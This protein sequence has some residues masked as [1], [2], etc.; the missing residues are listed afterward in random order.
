MLLKMHPT[1]RLKFISCSLKTLSVA[2]VSALLFVNAHAAGLGK[3][4]VLSALGQPLHAEIELTSVS[5]DDVGNMVP[6]LASVEAFRRANIEFNPALFSLRFAVEQRGGRQFIRVTSVQPINEP[7]VD[8]LLELGGAGNHLV[9]EYTFLLDP[10]ELR[11]SQ[12]PQASP[13]I[14]LPPAPQIGRAHV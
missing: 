8:M 6:K 13:P 12:S 7:F 2:V 14:M 4:T 5:K 10:A 9:R 11:S 1:T 3:L